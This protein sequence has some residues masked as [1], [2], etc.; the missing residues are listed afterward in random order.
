MELDIWAEDDDNQSAVHRRN[1]DHLAALIRA[2][3]IH[4]THTPDC[5]VPT[6]CHGPAVGE[7]MRSRSRIDFDYPGSLLHSAIVLLDQ[8]GADHE[9]LAAQAM[10]TEIEL[11]QARAELAEVREMLEACEDLAADVRFGPAES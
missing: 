10:A 5:P 8:R 7:I 1:T 2:R 6:V 11:G 9:A 3:R 4:T